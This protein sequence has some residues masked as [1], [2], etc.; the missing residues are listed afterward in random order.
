MQGGNQVCQVACIASVSIQQLKANVEVE[1]GLEARTLDIYM[2]EIERPLGDSV[3][4]D[5]NNQVIA[6]TPQHVQSLIC[7]LLIDLI[8]QRMVFIPGL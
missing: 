1:A 4:L 8:L 6:F 3:T 5:D 7:S 2:P